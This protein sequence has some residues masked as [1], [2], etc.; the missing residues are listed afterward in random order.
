MNA[1]GRGL[2]PLREENKVPT[3]FFWGGLIVGV[4]L[5]SDGLRRFLLPSSRKDL[6]GFVLYVVIGVLC[7]AIAGY[8]RAF[9]LDEK[10]L[11]QETS[12]LGR[13]VTRTL[14]PWQDVRSAS[15]E[16]SGAA[17]LGSKSVKWLIR[18]RPDEKEAFFTWIRSSKADVMI[19]DF[20]EQAQPVRL[21]EDN[22]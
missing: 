9:I 22:L 16:P 8:R 5:L 17:R 3:F 12:V 18:L 13:R 21:D 11:E 10:G 7:L 20:S 19:E 15:W 6:S 1:E 2:A 4:A 14:L